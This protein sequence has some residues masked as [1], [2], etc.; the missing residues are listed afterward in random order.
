MKVAGYE[1]DLEQVIKIIKDKNYKRVL[2]QVPEGLKTHV[3]EF[4]ELLEN[5]TNV[6]VIIF[7]DPCFGACDLI[8]YN[9][10]NFEI[11]LIVQIGHTPFPDIEKSMI[12]AA[13]E[14][15]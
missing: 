9:L 13:T 4:T 11:D 7:A 10:K 8:N 14:T 12:P 15:K 5:K 1:I 2:L 3:S 6:S